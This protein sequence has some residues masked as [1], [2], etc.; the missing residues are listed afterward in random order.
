MR[1][2]WIY[3]RRQGEECEVKGGGGGGEGEGVEGS[4]VSSGDICCSFGCVVHTC[5][6]CVIVSFF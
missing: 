1:S 4:S 2:S 3:S 6:R 5:V